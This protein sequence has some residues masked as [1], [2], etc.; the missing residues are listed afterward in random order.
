LAHEDLVEANEATTLGMLDSTGLAPSRTVRNQTIVLP[1][2]IVLVGATTDDARS[3]VTATDQA[4][5]NVVEAIDSSPIFFY[6]D[7]TTSSAL[8]VLSDPYGNR[9]SVTLRGLTG[10]ARQGEIGITEETLP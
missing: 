5:L 8:V 7:G 6:P 2:G 9:I 10:V 4:K 1:D 3:W